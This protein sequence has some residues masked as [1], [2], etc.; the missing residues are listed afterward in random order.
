MLTME[1]LGPSLADIGHIGRLCVDD[2]SG[3]IKLWRP[4]V[5]RDSRGLWQVL[6]I[7]DDDY[8]Y[9]GYGFRNLF[10]GKYLRAASSMPDGGGVSLV[11]ADQVDAWA[12]WYLRPAGSR[13]QYTITAGPSYYTDRHFDLTVHGGGPWSE[14]AQVISYHFLGGDPANQ[15][16]S[17]QFYSN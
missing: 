7:F 11:A 9:L 10:T 13:R 6:P 4:R 12:G 15:I 1:V 17:F 3:G 2:K 5:P 8:R 16:W 14:G